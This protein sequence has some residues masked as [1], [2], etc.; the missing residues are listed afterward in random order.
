MLSA[1]RLM[2]G[3]GGVVA[4]T[5]CLAA[6][7]ALALAAPAGASTVKPAAAVHYSF[8]TLDNHKDLTFNQLLGINNEGL[9][10]GY[11]GSGLTGHPNKGYLL[12]KPYH[13]NDYTNENFPGSA[14]TQVTGL[15]N[16]GNTVGF[17][18]NKAGANFGFYTSGTHFHEVN[19]PSVS[20]SSP[21]MDQLLGINDK[22]IAVG[23]YLN[24]KNLSRG[25]TYN[26]H[27]HKFG[28]VLLPGTSAS[29]GPTLTAAAINNTGYV[30]GYYN[31]SNGE[32]VAF[33]KRNASF[34]TLI[35]P[36]STMTQAFGVNDSGEVV[37][38]YVV[39]SGSSAV[40]HGFTWTVAHGFKTVNDPNGVNTTTI[41][42]LNDDGDLVGFYVDSKGN[43]DGF[44]AKP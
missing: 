43:T 15:N 26:I 12:T 10:S 1:N 30:A 40:M 3:I 24:A 42:G 36:H 2:L 27:T 41:N 17:W 18:A 8:T 6:V 32:T 22:G 7:G 31:L 33:L 16:V 25:Y 11:F 5:G 34:S 23:F 28:R 9:I 13:Q 4:A 20:N 35:V 38:D 39:G 21:Q 44:L 14:Q 19:F 29:N 37:G